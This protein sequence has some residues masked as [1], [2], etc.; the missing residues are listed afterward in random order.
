[1]KK[2]LRMVLAAALVFGLLPAVPVQAAAAEPHIA[3]DTVPK[4]EQGNVITGHIWFSGAAGRYSDYA[5]TLYLEIEPGGTR[6]GPKPTFATPSVNVDGNGHFELRFVTGGVDSSAQVLFALLV[7]ADHVPDGNYDNSS[8][9]ALSEAIIYRD[10]DGGVRIE[11]DPVHDKITVDGTARAGTDGSLEQPACGT[12]FTAF[13]TDAD[14]KTA[15]ANRK[16]PRDT[17]LLSMCYGTYIQGLS[18]DAGDAVPLETATYVLDLIAPY[19]DSIRLFGSSGELEKVYGVAKEQ[20]GLRV[21]GGCWFDARYTDQ[22][23]KAELDSLIALANNGLV[24]VAVVGSELLY[25]GDCGADKLVEYIHY[26]RAG[27]A[28]KQIPVTTSDTA[29]ALLDHPQVIKACDIVL[30]TSYPYYDKV[31]IDASLAQ[32]QDWYAKVKKAAGSK[33]VLVSETG[34]PTRPLS[35]RNGDAQPGVNNARQYVEAVYRWSREQNI[36]VFFFSAIDEDYKKANGIVE[37][38]FGFFRADGTMKD[39]Y[40]RLLAEIETEAAK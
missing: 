2:T 20:Y 12:I 40:K 8:G 26:V 19:T 14:T 28:D 3:I 11:A 30:F 21:V 37:D 24:D 1:M 31:S 29:Q 35:M 17:P 25:R 22:Q 27:I 32:L 7:P 36:E 5:V 39:A 23:I 33:Q 38:S 9:V 15:F 10:P 13:R 16:N 34:H 4:Y 6:W 18:P